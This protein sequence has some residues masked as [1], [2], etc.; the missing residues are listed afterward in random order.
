MAPGWALIY[1]QWSHASL[2]N[3]ALQSRA[4]SSLWQKMLTGTLS[5]RGALPA[6]AD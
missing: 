4:D 3:A 1:N 5:C 2:E 6:R